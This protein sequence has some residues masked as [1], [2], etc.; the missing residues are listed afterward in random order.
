[1]YPLDFKQK[2][3][4]FDKVILSPDLRANNNKKNTRYLLSN[5]KSLFELLGGMTL[6]V[7]C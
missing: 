4:C 6:M 3:R 2:H 1:M 7:I 5:Q